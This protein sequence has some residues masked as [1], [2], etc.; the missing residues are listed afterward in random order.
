MCVIMKPRNE[1]A[2]AH[3][4]L[5]S[6]GG[7]E[8]YYTI[9]FLCFYLCISHSYG[10]SSTHL[11]MKGG[12]VASLYS[13]VAILAASPML[14]QSISQKRADTV[15]VKVTQSF[16]NVR[17]V[18]PV[19]S[20]HWARVVPPEAIIGV[21]WKLY[22]YSS[23]HRSHWLLVPICFNSNFPDSYSACQYYFTAISKHDSSLPSPH[24][25]HTNCIQYW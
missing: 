6:H 14:R 9:S 20:S 17:G 3:I 15:V 7:G 22:H 5:S 11:A 18:E 13:S 23:Q 10:I 19:T 2:Q 16:T 4:G 24:I 8:Y 21:F 12:C 1:E 25:A